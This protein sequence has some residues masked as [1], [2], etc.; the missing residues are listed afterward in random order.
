MYYPCINIFRTPRL[1]LPSALL[2]PKDKL[3]LASILKG[4]PRC[5]LPTLMFPSMTPMK[6]G[7]RKEGGFYLSP[8]SH[9]QVGGQA[10][11]SSPTLE[12]C[13]RGGI[14]ED[15]DESVLALAALFI[16]CSFLVAAL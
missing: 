5:K 9:A 13:R 11:S 7:V 3:F 10:Y 6:E 15:E 14:E 2:R 8:S 4:R 16:L 12:I 1:D